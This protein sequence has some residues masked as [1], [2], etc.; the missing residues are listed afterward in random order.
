[1]CV[2]IIEVC[3]VGVGALALAERATNFSLFQT[4]R[5]PKSPPF[6]N[7]TFLN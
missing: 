2:E 6:A 5:G 3:V 4:S 7:V 1:M